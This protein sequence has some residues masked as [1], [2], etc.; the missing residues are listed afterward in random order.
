MNCGQPS[1]KPTSGP[2]SAADQRAARKELSRLERR[3]ETLQKK[4]AKL[5]AAL[6]EAATDPERLL[7][8]DAELKAVMAEAEDVETQWLSAAESAEA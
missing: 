1:A 2:S 7:A 6:A 5:H 3:L 8:L 4:E